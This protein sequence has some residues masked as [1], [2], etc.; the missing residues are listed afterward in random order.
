MRVSMKS[1]MGMTLMKKRRRNDG[2]EYKEF[3][4]D[5]LMKRMN[6]SG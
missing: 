2:G 3:D 5:D 6:K 4:G 1:L